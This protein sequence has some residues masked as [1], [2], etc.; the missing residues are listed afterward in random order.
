M[1]E[2]YP[3]NGYNIENEWFD[4]NEL[5]MNYKCIYV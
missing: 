5:I 1:A 2:K 4:E 3:L